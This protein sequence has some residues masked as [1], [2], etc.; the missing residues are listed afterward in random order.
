MKRE[1][2][3]ILE[4]NVGFFETD[5]QTVALMAD[6]VAGKG[7]RF[8]R[9]EISDEFVIATEESRIFFEVRSVLKVH[10]IYGP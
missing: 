3:I 1:A 7:F 4:E 9:N 8:E 2:G 6:E 5:L 10:K